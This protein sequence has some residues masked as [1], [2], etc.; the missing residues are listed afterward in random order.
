MSA[1]RLIDAGTVSA[2]R[3]QALYHGLAHARTEDSPDTVVLA[4]PGE[5]YVCI[6]YHQ[7]LEQAVD[8]AFCRQRRLPIIRRETGGGVVYL[9]SDQLFAQWVMGPQRLPLRVDRRFELFCGPLVATYRELGVAASF[10]PVADVHVAG[11]KISG[12]GAAQIGVAEVMTGN[13]LFDFDTAAMAAVV[14]CPSAAFAAQ[15]GRS[16]RKYMTSMRRELGHV[17]ALETVTRC[18]A[19]HVAAALGAE[20]VPGELTEVEQRSIE[21]WQQRLGDPAAANRQ[22]GLRRPGVKIHEDVYVAERVFELRGR[23]VRLTARLFKGQIEEIAVAAAGDHGP[24]VQPATQPVAQP[25]GQ[26]ATQPV[27]QP[28]DQPATQ[29]SDQPA[30]WPASGPATWCASLSAA[31]VGVTVEPEPVRQA[32]EHYNSHHAEPLEV[33]TWTQAL[34][35]LRRPDPP[36]PGQQP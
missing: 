4:V 22:A 15:I 5:P 36:A 26:P 34:L 32:L 17:P 23:A 6:G 12:T 3:S 9:D 30:A 29:P 21:R 28:S 20:L 33:A 31:L 16:L 35:D 19:G 7:N 8:V 13:L 27:A 11:R 18:Y 25:A 24:A 10:R 14:R 2:L 1:V